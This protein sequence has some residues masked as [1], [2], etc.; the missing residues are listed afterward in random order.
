MRRPAA[1]TLWRYAPLQAHL[2]AIVMPTLGAGLVCAATWPAVARSVDSEKTG[3]V[4]RA[5]VLFSEG[6]RLL[7][8]GQISEACARFEMSY[9][10]APRGG[11]LLNLGLCHEKQ[12]RLVEAHAEL[13]AALAKAREDKREDRVPIAAEHLAAVAARLGWLD[14]APPSNVPYDELELTVDG[15]R[16]ARSEWRAVAVESGP[17]VIVAT[18]R[19]FHPR[20][21]DV[22][23]AATGGPVPV[24]I[25]SLEPL[26]ATKTAAA[27]ATATATATTTAATTTTATTTTVQAPPA[28]P[29][30]RWFWIAAGATTV[31][32]AGSL[33]LGLRAHGLRDTYH[34][35]LDDPGVSDADQRDA[36]DRATTAQ[37]LTTAA[38]VVTGALAATSFVLYLKRPAAGRSGGSAALAIAPRAL[39]LSVS[40]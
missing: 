30:S 28:R 31:S 13:S 19:G 9:R 27:T 15:R 32:A 22:P 39:L 40:F 35:A 3:D 24:S 5:D 12:A 11:T 29:L 33:V 26:A 20:R 21:V 8:G 17:H 10:L 16:L 18:A 23:V 36:Y 4:A 14:I 7:E 37:H 1:S 6:R 25:Q 38:V 34:D 2:L